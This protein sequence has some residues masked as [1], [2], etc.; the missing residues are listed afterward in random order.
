[1]NITFFENIFAPSIYSSIIIT[2]VLSIVIMILGM[3]I[4][5]LK[6]TDSPKGI[7]M[8]LELIVGF[9]NDFSKDNFGKYWKFF[10]P[11]MLTLAIFLIFYTWFKNRN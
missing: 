2:I 11:Y 4:R 6:P 1:M 10:A 7:L 9:V 8:L 3:R 5:K